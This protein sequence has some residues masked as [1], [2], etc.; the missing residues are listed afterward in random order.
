MLSNHFVVTGIVSYR[1][2]INIIVSSR[3]FLLHWV[4]FNLASISEEAG[5]CHLLA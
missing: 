3:G 5:L 2:S 1:D 4:I